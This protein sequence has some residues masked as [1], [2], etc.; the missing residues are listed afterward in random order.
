M[1]ISLSAKP[2]CIRQSLKACQLYHEKFLHL[3]SVIIPPA[4]TKYIGGI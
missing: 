1:I 2:D 4:Y 3:L